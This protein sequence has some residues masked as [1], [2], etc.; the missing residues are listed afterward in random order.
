MP[1]DWRLVHGNYLKW[2]GNKSG[3][4]K[5]EIQRDIADI[6]N[7]KGLEIG[8]QRERPPEQKLRGVNPNFAKQNS[9]LKIRVT[10]FERRWEK[11]KSAKERFRHCL[12]QFPIMSERACMDAAITTDYYDIRDNNELSDQVHGLDNGDEIVVKTL[13]QRIAFPNINTQEIDERTLNSDADNLD[14]QEVKEQSIL[15]TSRHGVNE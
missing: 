1:I 12:T 7:K 4:S 8:I 9:G 10:G 3:V 2:K 11:S 15:K 13:L 6:L 14:C 5:R